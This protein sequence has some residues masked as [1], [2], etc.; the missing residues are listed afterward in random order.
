M[1][2]VQQQGQ[3]VGTAIKKAD[4]QQNK[5]DDDVADQQHKLDKQ[6]GDQVRHA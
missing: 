4:D 6:V 5:L 2:D 3:Q 1:Q